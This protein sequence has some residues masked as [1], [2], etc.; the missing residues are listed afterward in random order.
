MWW[1][2]DTLK[3]LEFLPD[4][5]TSTRSQR[6]RW[7]Y[8]NNNFPYQEPFKESCISP[9]LDASQSYI[10]EYGEFIIQL[11]SLPHVLSCSH[12]HLIIWRSQFPY[13]APQRA[14]MD[15][16][17]F[18]FVWCDLKTFHT[19]QRIPRHHSYLPNLSM[20]KGSQAYLYLSA[21]NPNNYIISWSL[22]PLIL[23]IVFVLISFLKLFMTIWSFPR[24]R[25]I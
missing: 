4:V 7:I 22:S 10:L 11:E 24:S 19:N 8:K 17:L 9:W 21:F 18:L 5:L 1:P 14:I 12:P 16:R 25:I 6:I 2:G 3:H 15:Q 23:L 20:F 13:S